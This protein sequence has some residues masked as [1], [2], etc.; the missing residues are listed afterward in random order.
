MRKIRDV[1]RHPGVALLQTIPGVGVRTASAVAAYIDDPRR[2][3]HNRAIGR[4]FGIT[5]TQD[6]SGSVNRLGHISHEGPSTVRH[7]ITE[8]AWHGTRLSPTIRAYFER[9]MQGNKERR[10]IALVATGHY[11]L[12]VMHAMFRDGTPWQESTPPASSMVA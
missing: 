5:P 6:A 8:A 3:R 11:L 4:Y 12:R 1:I 9:I 10:K 7:L 2:F